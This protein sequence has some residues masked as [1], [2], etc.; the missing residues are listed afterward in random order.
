[1]EEVKY[2]YQLYKKLL[3][4]KEDIYSEAQNLAKDLGI[5][6]YDEG[7]GLTG[8]I[9]GMP[10]PLRDNILKAMEEGSKKIFPLKRLIDELREVVKD[11]YGDGYDVVST[12]T[13]EA[14]LWLSFDVL[15]SPPMQGRGGN[16]R[17]RYI[18][19]YEK[20]L[21]HQGSY[22]RPFPGKYKDLLSDRGSTP[23]ELGFYG[24]RQNNLDMVLA[25]LE[26]AKYE[27]HGIKYF[28]TLQLND[29]D[30]EGSI[31]NIKKIAKRQ[32]SSL[33]AFTSLGYDTPGYGYGAKDED[34]TPTLQR[35]IG[36]LSNEYDAPYIVDNAWGLPFL[37]VDPRKTNADVVAYS[38]DKAMA[39]PTSGMIIGKEEVMVQLR[40]ALGVHGDRW[41]T[42]GSYGKSAYVTFDPGKEA[43][44]GQL[45]VLK[46]LRD[47]PEIYNDLVDKT[48]EIVKE[49]FEKIDPEL[50]KGIKINKSYN[51]NAVEVNYE[52]TWKENGFGIPIF[53]IE[54]MYASSHLIQNGLKQMGVIPTIAYDGNIFIS[55]GQGTTDN[56]GKL[57]EERMRV[58]VKALV[59]LMEIISRHA[60]VI[61]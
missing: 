39:G 29:V 8:C 9:S 17:A 60:G 43:L 34:G 41:G 13:C 1:M 38:V 27:P 37:G 14:A 36:E 45:E 55:A 18:A 4:E 11:V 26:G 42:T 54:D 61:D 51:S 25:R 50:R 7:F 56:K 21:H 57:I 47:N 48:Y 12:P 49:E 16:Y 58:A 24:K 53:S 44:L 35:M 59:G 40:R 19:L 32:A 46:D 2:K 22:G 10:A 31:E 33:T 20:H 15:A 30:P 52:D 5:H 3:S 6:S 23:G 28:P